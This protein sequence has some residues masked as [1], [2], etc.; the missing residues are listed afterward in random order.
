M[1]IIVSKP[2]VLV[3]GAEAFLKEKLEKASTDEWRPLF[4]HNFDEAMAVMKHTP[5]SCF[6]V[7]P[8]AKGKDGA[9]KVTQFCR[10]FETIP[11]ILYDGRLQAFDLLEEIPVAIKRR[12]F[13]PDVKIFGIDFEQCSKRIKK[14]VRMMMDEFREN[15]TVDEIAHRLGVHRSHL[16]REWHQQCGGITAKQL[17]IGLKLHYS[18]FLRGH[19]KSDVMVNKNSLDFF[20][21]VSSLNKHEKKTI[22]H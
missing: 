18:T 7:S 19:L 11:A 10:Q 4:V 14:T 17:L 12:A 5:V 6:V 21:F 13:Q 15:I 9:T 2:A 1:E 3:L 16:E 20:M 8:Y 22:R